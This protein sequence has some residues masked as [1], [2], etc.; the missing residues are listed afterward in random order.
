MYFMLRNTVNTFK[1]L[2]YLNYNLQ[3]YNYI[4]HPLKA[5]QQAF[6]TI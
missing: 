3:Q 2:R 1:T 5:Y 4:F 6:D